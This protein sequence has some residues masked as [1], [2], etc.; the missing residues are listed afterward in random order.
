MI[1]CEC[2]SLTDRQVREKLEE[3]ACCLSD[4]VPK[5]A[6]EGSCGACFQNIKKMIREYR[7]ANSS[8]SQPSSADPMAVPVA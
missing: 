1:V 5:T 8:L 4:L 3:G 6:L 7:L 2:L